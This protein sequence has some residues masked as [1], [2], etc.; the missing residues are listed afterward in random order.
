MNIYELEEI[1]AAELVR[2]FFDYNPETGKLYHR[3]KPR[4]YFQTERGWKI[5]NGK[6]TPGEEVVGRD[7][8]RGYLQVCVLGKMVQLHRLVWLHYYGSWPEKQ[9]DHINQ[10]KTDNR[11]SNL[12]DV[13]NRQNS[14]NKGIISTNT[15]GKTG[16][17]FHKQTGKWLS[18]IKI[19][20][21]QKHLGLFEEFEDAVRAREEAELKYGY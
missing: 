13:S 6:I 3:E 2:A 5:S 10:I 15:S 4:E 17:C 11:I 14:L 21:K 1:K 19:R 16:V 9:I 7:N 12:R 20:G 18:R 8:G